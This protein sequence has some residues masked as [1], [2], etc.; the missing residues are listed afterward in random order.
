M[1]NTIEENV[2]VITGVSSGLGEATA[3]QLSAQSANVVLGRSVG[4]CC[5]TVKR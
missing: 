3:Q 1:S 5:L 4:K 2:L